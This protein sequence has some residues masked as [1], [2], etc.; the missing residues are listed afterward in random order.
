M[1]FYSA[2]NVYLSSIQQGIQ[3]AH[4][5]GEMVLRSSSNNLVSEWLEHHKTLICVNGGNNSALLEL[6]ALFTE[7]NNPGYPVAHFREDE[8]SM[9]GM[10]TTVG[11]IVPEKIYGIDPADATT[12]AGLS[13]W[14]VRLAIA[15]KRLPLAR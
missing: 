5:V 6:H 13:E 8:A 7:V 4:C 1:R 2:G 10:L 15:L 9:D 3:A 14:E 12:W 11:I